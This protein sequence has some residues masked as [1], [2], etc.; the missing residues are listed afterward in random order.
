MEDMNPREHSLHTPVTVDEWANHVQSIAAL[1]PARTAS[2]PIAQAH[3]LRLASPLIA[4]EPAPA[5]AMSAMDGFAIR[6]C[7]LPTLRK[8]ADGS[9]FE[10]EVSADL[11]A[12]APMVG[13]LRDGAAVRIMTGAPV[14]SGFDVVLP[15]EATNADPYAASA[16][17]HIT[18]FSRSHGR[19]S[20]SFEPGAHIRQV[21]EE[22]ARGE[23]LA[24]PGDILTSQLVG[25]ALSVGVT[26]VDVQRPRRVAIIMTGD[27]LVTETRAEQLRDGNSGEDLGAVLESNGPMLAAALAEVG[28]EAAVHHVGD[29]PQDL[30]AVARSLASRADLIITTGGVGSGAR[31]VVKAAFGPGVVQAPGLGCS[32]FEHV[33]MRPGGPQGVGVLDVDGARTPMVHLPGTPVG[34]LVGFHLFIRPLW[35]SAG[36]FH[37]PSAHFVPHNADRPRKPGAAVLAVRLNVEHGR[38]IATEI[39]GP[40]LRPFADADALAISDDS[41]TV[42]L[43]P[44][45]C[46]R[47]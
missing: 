8:G 30:I 31:D 13:E 42:T 18:V 10:I 35:G 43:V 4:A 41:E 29:S 6:T 21:G 34:A 17:P 3:G 38:V 12:G 16:P 47:D 28:A 39:P 22:I 44:L 45:S 37:V 26:A 36:A 46:T 40:R 9:L 7:D 27:E 25:M 33:F 15:V 14:P 1:G 2:V 24:S 5:F 20:T 11:A 23:V 32:R 19:A